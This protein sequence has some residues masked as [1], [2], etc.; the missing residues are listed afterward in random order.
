MNYI[1]EHTVDIKGG[2]VMV[3]VVGLGFVILSL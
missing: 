2:W 3:L 1:E